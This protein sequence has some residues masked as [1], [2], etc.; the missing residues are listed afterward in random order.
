MSVIEIKNISHSFGEK[1]ILNDTNFYLYEKEKIGL[2]GVN[3]AG[4]S[5]LL[6][7]IANK[8]SLDSFDM[9][10]NPKT[11]IGYLDQHGSLG[12]NITVYQ[13]LENAFLKFKLLEDEMNN[14]YLEFSQNSSLNPKKLEKAGDIQN[15]LMY[16]GYYEKD[17][18][19]KYVT[20]GLNINESWLNKNVEEM[21]GGQRTKILLCKLLIEKPDVLLL[22]EPTNFLDVEHINW[23]EKYLIEYENELIIISHDNKFINNICNVIWHFENYKLKRYKGNFNQFQKAYE[24]EREK[25]LKSYENQQKLIDKTKTFIA[26]NIAR[27]STSGIAKSRQKMLD[28]IEKIEIAPENKKSQFNFKDKSSPPRNII[29]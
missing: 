22:D 29:T 21:S 11:S 8:I 6:K 17:Q 18:K 25:T 23:L 26:K 9:Y 15:I 19:I 7:A 12:N 2:I 14:I 20:S 1:T 13:C 4:K 3:G 28:K 5:T 27:A 10:V 24:L 16:S